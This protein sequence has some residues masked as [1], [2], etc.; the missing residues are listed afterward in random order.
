MNVN[1]CV[2]VC[3]HACVRWH[4]SV[5][6][7]HLH[8]QA[9]E[10]GAFLLTALTM[11]VRVSIEYALA[12]PAA[13]AQCL[14]RVHAALRMFLWQVSDAVGF[15]PFQ[16]VPCGA[17][18]WLLPWPHYCERWALRDS[19]CGGA[20]PRAHSCS[21]TAAVSSNARD[22]DV[23]ATC[24]TVLLAGGH[25]VE[26]AEVDKVQGDRRARFDKRN[27]PLVRGGRVIFGAARRAA[28]LTRLLMR[29]AC[30]S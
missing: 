3:V 22:L 23:R 6:V 25:D 2:C 30:A 11:L 24:V 20:R 12:S 15:D 1:V 27:I 8:P 26:R 7:A 19:R 28:S 17:R 16:P 14:L 4:V 9:F 29:A 13:S 10:L 21:H 18:G 5:Y